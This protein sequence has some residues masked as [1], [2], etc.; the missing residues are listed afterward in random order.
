LVNQYAVY[1]VG[2]VK[3]IYLSPIIVGVTTQTG[4]PEPVVTI[5]PPPPHATCRVPTPFTSEVRTYPAASVPSAILN[6][7]GVAEAIC[8]FVLGVTVPIPIYLPEKSPKIN[9]ITLS[10]LS[11]HSWL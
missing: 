9:G 1:T 4:L 5:G 11:I 10:Q 7:P 2:P 6:A 3:S 8:S